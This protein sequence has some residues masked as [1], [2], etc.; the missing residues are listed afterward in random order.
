MS[1]DYTVIVANAGTVVPPIARGN[2]TGA[3]ALTLAPPLP[4]LSR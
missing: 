2:E 3:S 4:T 1:R